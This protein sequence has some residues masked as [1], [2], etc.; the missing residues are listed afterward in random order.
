MKPDAP[1]PPGSGSICPIAAGLE[2][3]GDRW[4]LLVIRDLLLFGKRRFGELAGSS[5]KIP[6]N[7]LAERLRRLEAAG[8]IHKVLYQ[9]APPRHEYRPTAKGVDLLPVLRALVEWA[10]LHLPGTGS[11]P[12]GFFDALARRLAGEKNAAPADRRAEAEDAAAETI[13]SG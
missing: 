11:P 12:P 3:L 8:V 13:E 7:I 10:N 4:S 1:A 6:T 5:E 2:L 9:T